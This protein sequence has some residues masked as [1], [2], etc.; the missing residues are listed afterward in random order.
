MW[1]ILLGVIYSVSKERESH[2]DQHL[3]QIGINSVTQSCAWLLTSLILNV[4]PILLIIIFLKA[5]KLLIFIDWFYLIMYGTIYAISSISTALF[6]SICSRRFSFNALIFLALETA[7]FFIG[8]F[9]P[10]AP[11]PWRDFF[12]ILSIYI[13]L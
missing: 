5:F 6:L 10:Y 7:P 1:I 13:N 9:P 2:L 8:S 11:R 4:P 12:V 3:K